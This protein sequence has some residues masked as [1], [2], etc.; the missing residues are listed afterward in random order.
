MLFNLDL[1]LAE[2]HDEAARH[3]DRIET[4]TLALEE[5]KRGPGYP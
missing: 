2:E 4:M 5:W 1:D 3:P